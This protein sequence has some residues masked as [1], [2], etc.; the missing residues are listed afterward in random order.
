VFD[1]AD[2]RIDWAVLGR[3]V[4]E[5]LNGPIGSRLLAKAR[6]Q[7]EAAVEMLKVVSPEDPVAIRALQ[8]KIQ[9]ADSIIGWLGDAVHEGEVA[10]AHLEVENDG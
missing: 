4:E 8:T 5:F 3:Q 7:S 6:A 2:P 10:L 1:P 9:V